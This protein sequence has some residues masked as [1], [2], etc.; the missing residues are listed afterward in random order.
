MKTY[1]SQKKIFKFFFFKENLQPVLSLPTFFLHVPK[2][3]PSPLYDQTHT[4]RYT[5]TPPG[6]ECPRFHYKTR[7]PGS[8]PPR[9]CLLRKSMG[10]I[11]SH[12]GPATDSLQKASPGP[13]ERTTL[14]CHLHQVREVKASTSLG[15]KVTQQRL[16]VF[17]RALTR[18]HI[19]QVCL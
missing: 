3:C 15:A 7:D 16:L 19:H 6:L 8:T 1:H 14:W 2:P 12:V 5:H 9:P 4:H 18:A 17:T 13:R 11:G 10:S